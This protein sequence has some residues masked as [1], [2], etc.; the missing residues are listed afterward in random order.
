MLTT[1]FFMV[2][3]KFPIVLK[4]IQIF[5]VYTCQSTKIIVSNSRKMNLIVQQLPKIKTNLCLVKENTMIFRQ[6]NAVRFR[7]PK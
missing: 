5:S 1:N 6:E 4:M 3:K 2:I 7:I